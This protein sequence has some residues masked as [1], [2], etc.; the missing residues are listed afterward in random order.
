MGQST[1]GFGEE[2][3]G[4]R[5][6]I[7]SETVSLSRLNYYNTHT[8][9]LSSGMNW[10]TFRLY[11]RSIHL[12]KERAPRKFEKR[13]LSIWEKWITQKDGGCGNGVCLCTPV[14]NCMEQKT[15]NSTHWGKC[16]FWTGKRLQF[17][18]HADKTWMKTESKSHG[19]FRNW[20]EW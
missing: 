12:Q 8:S 6:A 4:E 7:D 20:S 18:V 19:K 11:G 10:G 13:Q 15:R 17:S 3:E 9:W 2:S 1:G 5:I 16:K 14:R